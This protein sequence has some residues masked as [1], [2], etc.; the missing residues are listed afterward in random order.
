MSPP[1]EIPPLPDATIL[2]VELGSTA[3]GTGIPGGEDHDEIGVVVETP[4]D[5]VCLDSHGFRTVMQRTQPEGEPSG[6]GD[7]DRTLHA[8]RQFLRLCAVGN[9]SILMTFWAPIEFVTPEGH[10]LRALSDA[11]VGRHVIPRYRGYMQNQGRR[12][13]GLLGDADASPTKHAMHAARLGFQGVELLTTGRL[14]LPIQG[15]P[16]DWLRA[17]RR[18]DVAFDDWWARC[19]DL[20]AQLAALAEDE[21]IPLLAD[22]ARIDAW[23]I[24]VHRRFWA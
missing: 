4:A 24:D 7:V 3:H 6:P 18:G 5:L 21:S 20:D 13:L 22:R 19:L 17:V 1:R 8:L 14:Q 11:F 23:S 9:P 10:E 16:A 15:E 2:L 12:A